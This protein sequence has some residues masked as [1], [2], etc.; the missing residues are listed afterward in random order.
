MAKQINLNSDQ[1]K[2]L[3]SFLEKKKG[4]AKELAKA[5][6]L[7]MYEKKIEAELIIEITGL[8]WIRKLKL[9]ENIVKKKV[10]TLL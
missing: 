10:K 2:A 5:Q 9:L 3:R 8:S 6:A 7:F 1:I 4:S